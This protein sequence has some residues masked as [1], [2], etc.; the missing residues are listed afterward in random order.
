MSDENE[1]IQFPN[2]NEDPPIQGQNKYWIFT[3]FYYDQKIDYTNPDGSKET[4]TREE[5]IQKFATYYCSYLTYG[6][7]KATTTLTPHLQ[8][9]MVLKDKKRFSFIK[10]NCNNGIHLKKMKSCLLA[11]IIY[12][13]KEKDWWTYKA[14][15]FTE[16]K[17]PKTL[18][19]KK[20]IERCNEAIQKAKY[21]SILD[22][23][24]DILIGN[25]KNLQQI[26]YLEISKN[27]ELNLLLGTKFG[28]YFKNHFLWL[29]GPTGTLKSYNTHKIGDLL[30]NWLCKYNDKNNYPLP[31]ASIWKIPYIKDL[32]KW[33]QNYCFEKIMIIE[34]ADLTFCKNNV[35]RLKRWLDQY[36]FPGEF[37]GGDVGLIRPEFII[38]TSNYSL[39]ECFTQE[40]MS[41]EKDYLPMKRRVME[42]ELSNKGYLLWPNLK[43]LTAEY[44]SK[45]S[46][47]EY[48]QKFTET[49][50]QLQEKLFG[51]LYSTEKITDSNKIE[52][53][54][55]NYVKFIDLEKSDEILNNN[56]NC[57]EKLDIPQ[58][59]NIQ[60]SNSQETQIIT[61]IPESPITPKHQLEEPATSLPNTPKKPKLERQNAILIDSQDVVIIGEEESPLNNKTKYVYAEDLPSYENQL[62]SPL[63]KKNNK[64]KE[65]VHIMVINKITWDSS[66]PKCIN[67][68]KKSNVMICSDCRKNIKKELNTP[69][70]GKQEYLYYCKR[71]GHYEKKLPLGFC[72][73]CITYLKERYNYLFKTPY[74]STNKK[75]DLTKYD[76]CN[77]P[78]WWNSCEN[79][80]CLNTQHIEN[81]IF[82]NEGLFFDYFGN[83]FTTE[84]S[85]KA[86]Y[87][88]LNG[89]RNKI[90]YTNNLNP[91]VNEK[92]QSKIDKTIYDVRK[93][94]TTYNLQKY[95]F[96]PIKRRWHTSQE[97]WQIA[98]DNKCFYCRHKCKGYN[99]THYIICNCP[100]YLRFPHHKW[101]IDQWMPDLLY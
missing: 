10:K 29:K 16:P 86:I 41:H 85:Y 67:C 82:E 95:N 46:A 68:F 75:L 76:I 48:D 42:I 62:I 14:E 8:G 38:I 47:K 73:S 34:E 3:Q 53:L 83:I 63:Y 87:K 31:N 25:L 54:L 58:N 26:K 37:K 36:A 32:N 13:H 74:I 24:S 80:N 90:D 9:C 88:L 60:L 65:P 2:L 1:P 55:V 7:E 64:G 4:I 77:N 101:W 66:I 79:M 43:L 78:C 52:E 72:D 17:K 96:Y 98:N 6:K 18:I 50:Y 35:S 56:N 81:K 84:K 94:I 69:C 91:N 93:M 100:E 51:D 22:I 97:L 21:G 5:T 89:I 28:N 19:S 57:P 49:M 39:E 11:N 12:C 20:Y 44:N 23:D 40:G 27:V 15:N 61:R 99:N 33:F 45:Q 92:D 70:T 59:N 30:F 71:C